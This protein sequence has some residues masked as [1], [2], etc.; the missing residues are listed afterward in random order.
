MTGE[1]RGEGRDREGLHRLR[2]PPGE[3]SVPDRL[4]AVWRLAAGRGRDPGGP[5]PAVPGLGPDP[6]QGRGRRVRPQGGGVDHPG[7]A[8]PQVQPGTRRR[9]R[10]LRRRGRP[11]P[12]RSASWRTGS[13]SPR[14]WPNSRPASAPA[15]YCA[16]STSSPSTRPPPR[17][18]AAPE[19]SRAR[20][21]EP[22]TSSATTRPSPNSQLGGAEMT[23][24]T[25]DPDGPRDRPAGDVH[26]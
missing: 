14:P 5:D 15:S 7:R 12:T 4:P 18:T 1:G 26:P 23:T 8:A 6:A 17:S 13:S 11:A 25:E 22:S 19:R 9:R 2:H 20:R 21:C 10:V 3:R 24:R 16:T